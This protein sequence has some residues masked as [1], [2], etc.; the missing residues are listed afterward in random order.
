VSVYMRMSPDGKV[1]RQYEFESL[2]TATMF[3]TEMKPSWYTISTQ[4]MT[5]VFAKVTR[6]SNPVWSVGA[7]SYFPGDVTTTKSDP[8]IDPRD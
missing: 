7:E 6:R 3:V 2:V 5:G 4:P 1:T 8:I